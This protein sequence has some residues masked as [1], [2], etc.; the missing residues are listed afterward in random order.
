MLVARDVAGSRRCGR[1]VGGNDS[2]HTRVAA[3]RRERL[4]ERCLKPRVGGGERGAAEDK[5]QE[6]A[7]GFLLRVDLAGDQLLGFA[8]RQVRAEPAI[9]RERPAAEDGRDRQSKQQPGNHE[10][11]PSEPVDETAPALKHG[12]KRYMSRLLV[13]T[14]AGRSRGYLPIVISGTT[15]CWP[16][17]VLPR[18]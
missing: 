7:R 9:V 2:G 8:G 18:H 14:T 5:R 12:H 6:R 4:L 11:G 16:G 15:G 17:P 10:G 13:P 3:K 1:R